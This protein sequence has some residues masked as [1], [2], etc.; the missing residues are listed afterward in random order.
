[1]INDNTE[2]FSSGNVNFTVYANCAKVS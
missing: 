2:Y 1:M